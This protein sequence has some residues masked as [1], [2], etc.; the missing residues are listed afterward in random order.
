MGNT[1]L[2]GPVEHV[3]VLM[4]ENRSFDNV[5][6]G[7]KPY[8]PNFEG[9]PPKWFNLNSA[10]NEKIFAFQAEVG[11]KARTMPH[12][13]PKEDHNDMMAQINNGKMDGFVNNYATVK[14]ADPKD[15]MQYYTSDNIPITSLL[16]DA[17]AVSDQYHGSGPV[18]N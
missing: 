8:G 7:L 13:D 17:Y 14:N 11:R 6:G 4:F 18:Q 1:K 12:P 9:V 2:L 15:I 16:A 5:L 3:V 10:T